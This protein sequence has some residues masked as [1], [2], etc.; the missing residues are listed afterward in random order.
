MTSAEPITLEANINGATLGFEF[1]NSTLT[2]LVIPGESSH[3]YLNSG[4]TYSL[5][6]NGC[7]YGVSG[8]NY[9]DFGTWSIDSS[10]NITINTLKLNTSVNASN[11]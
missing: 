11:L 5:N 8:D 4:I 10:N 2:Q 6:D 3:T 1:D 7:V 9:V